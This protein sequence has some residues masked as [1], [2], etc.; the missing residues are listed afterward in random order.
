MATLRSLTAAPSANW[1]ML[2]G[3]AFTSQ[4]VSN[5]AGISIDV[6]N[7]VLAAFSL[8]EEARND[9]FNSLH[10]F[11]I[12]NA[13]PLLRRNAQ[14]FVLFQQVSLLEAL[15]EAPFYW[16]GADPEYS[17]IALGHRGRFTEAFA[18]ERLEHVFGRA[19]VHFNVRVLRKKGEALGEI[20]VLVLFGDR[21]IVLQAKSKR[22]T[23]EAR[24]GNDLQIKDDFKK[25]EDAY[26]Q[27]SLCAL[28]LDDPDCKLIDSNGSSVEI[29]FP[30]KKIYLMCILADHYPALSFQARQF[31]NYH[32]SDKIAP[33]LATDVF[34]L[35]AQAEF[36]DSPLHFLSYLDLRA[37]FGRKVDFH[38]RAYVPFV[39][40]EAKSLGRKSLRYGDVGRFYCRRPR[41]CHARPTQRSSRRTNAGRHTNAPKKHTSGPNAR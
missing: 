26:D 7:K 24:K 13:T 33:P 17:Q 8:S 21:A 20:D 15:Y 29:A 3:F 11:N 38:A 12:T 9:G 41:R 14:E 1:T 30:L 36:L 39:P 4:E 16:M 6:V 5:R 35:D 22:M 31:L 34:A 37:R 25:A 10:D 28:A 27:A 32:S 23:R 2:P 40:F 18:R 19:H